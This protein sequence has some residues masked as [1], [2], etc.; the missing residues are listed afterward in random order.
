MQLLQKK[1]YIYMYILPLRKTI[2]R[3]STPLNNSLS[4]F[5][6]YLKSAFPLKCGLFLFFF[7]FKT[8]QA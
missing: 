5:F 3:S 1:K 4:W 6:D 7:F 2:L 8:G